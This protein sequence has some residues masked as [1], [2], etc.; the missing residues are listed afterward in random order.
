MTVIL[1]FVNED[2]TTVK[3]GVR[4]NDRFSLELYKILGRFS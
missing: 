3:S 4:R 2:K 1:A